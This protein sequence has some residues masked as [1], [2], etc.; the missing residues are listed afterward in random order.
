MYIKRYPL[1]CYCEII[2]KYTIIYIL[3]SMVSYLY[4]ITNVILINVYYICI[5]R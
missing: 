3:Y 4:I 5:V 1:L 2:K